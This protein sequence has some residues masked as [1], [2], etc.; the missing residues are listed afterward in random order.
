MLSK[1]DLETNALN[2]VVALVP[3]RVLH[4]DRQRYNAPGNTVCHTN[5]PEQ[6]HLRE[7]ELATIHTRLACI[8][9]PLHTVPMFSYYVAPGLS[10]ACIRPG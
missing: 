6:V 10:I 9:T 5:S 2:P 7:N 8:E 4:F 1:D 3:R